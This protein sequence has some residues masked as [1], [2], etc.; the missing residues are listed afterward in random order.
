[1]ATLFDKIRKVTYHIPRKEDKLS[2]EARD[3]IVRLLQPNPVK[4]LTAKEVLN[5]PW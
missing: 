1:M 3:L 5:H 4:R 2:S